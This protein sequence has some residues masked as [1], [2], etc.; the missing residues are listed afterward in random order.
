MITYDISSNIATAEE[1]K[2]I[3]FF[4]KN[5]LRVKTILL[6]LISLI[7]FTIFF[8][9]IFYVIYLGHTYFQ[10]VKKLRT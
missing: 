3:K 5:K 7:P 2:Q 8:G 6:Y 4:S 9:A 1:D 10:E